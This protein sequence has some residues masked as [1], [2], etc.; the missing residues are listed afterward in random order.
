MKKEEIVNLT[1]KRI[2][3][4]KYYT[5]PKIEAIASVREITKGGGS[6]LADAGGQQGGGPPSD[7]T[8]SPW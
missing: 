5:T 6:I 1:I 7:P 4:K 8:G 2:E 3:K